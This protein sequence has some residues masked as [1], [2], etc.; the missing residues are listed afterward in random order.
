MHHHD[1]VFVTKAL[2]VHCCFVVFVVSLQSVVVFVVI[3]VVFSPFVLGVSNLTPF[4]SHQGVLLGLSA[5]YKTG[6]KNE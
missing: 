6:I 5:L 2:I 3:V 1:S 4:W